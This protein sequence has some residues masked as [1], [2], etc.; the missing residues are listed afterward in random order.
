MARIGTLS[1]PRP[2]NRYRAFFHAGIAR[3][4]MFRGQDIVSGETGSVVKGILSSFAF[5]DLLDHKDPVKILPFPLIPHRFY[6]FLA[7][8]EVRDQDL[9]KGVHSPP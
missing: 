7:L 1:F 3:F 8:H 5:L 2:R 9:L 6:Y 4:K